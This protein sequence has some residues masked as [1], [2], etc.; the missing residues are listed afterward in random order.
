VKTGKEKLAI[1]QIEEI[2]KVRPKDVKLL[3][4]LAV[5]REKNGDLD[6]ALEAY[7][8]IIEISP[9]HKDAEE[10]YLRLRLRRVKDEG[11]E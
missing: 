10:A 8:R 9:G 5:L 7:K 1:K 3:M 2:L 6:G 4:H 11:A